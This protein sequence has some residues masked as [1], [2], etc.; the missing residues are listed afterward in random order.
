MKLFFFSQTQFLF[1]SFAFGFA[2]GLWFEVFR[3][4]RRAVRHGVFAVALE[5]LAFFIPTAAAYWILCFGAALGRLRWFSF[6]ALVLG[7]LV[8]LMSLGR[9]LTAL[10]GAIIAF[11]KRLVRLILKTIAVPVRALL[12]A[13]VRPMRRLEELIRRRI[14]FRRR[15]RRQKS[16][17]RA[18]SRGF[19]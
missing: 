3:I 4:I 6:F 17:L 10:S 12:K 13:A 19:R 7:F 11:V 14:A 8:Y 1:L 18:A 2:A 9:L 16:F 5:D 15:S